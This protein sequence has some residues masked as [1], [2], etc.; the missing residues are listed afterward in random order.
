[1][2]CDEYFFFIKEKS[3]L[4][5]FDFWIMLGKEKNYMIKFQDLSVEW[6]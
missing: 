5:E 2:Q 6:I 3:K 1:M 4:Q